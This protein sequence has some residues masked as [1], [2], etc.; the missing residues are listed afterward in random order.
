MTGLLFLVH[1]VKFASLCIKTCENRQHIYVFV[2]LAIDGV[3]P[4]YMGYR[5]FVYGNIHKHP[6]QNVG[7]SV[8]EKHVNSLE[9]SYINLENDLEKSH[10]LPDSGISPK[11]FCPS[12]HF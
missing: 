9:F 4:H 10:D 5:A 2:L 12:G 1:L 7:A 3:T 6:P 8:R 11:S